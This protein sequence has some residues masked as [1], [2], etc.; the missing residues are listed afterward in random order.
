[1]HSKMGI[2]DDDHRVVALEK[3]VANNDLSKWS[4]I[5]TKPASTTEKSI[6]MRMAAVYSIG[7]ERRPVEQPDS[8]SL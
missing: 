3:T 2:Y 6:A 7:L 4:P 5:K 1:M 8:S